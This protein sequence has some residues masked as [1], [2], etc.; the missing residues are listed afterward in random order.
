MDRDVVTDDGTGWGCSNV[1]TDGRGWGGSDPNFYRGELIAFARNPDNAKLAS[2]CAAALALIAAAAVVE[3]RYYLDADIPRAVQDVRIE[4]AIA[5]VGN[6]FSETDIVLRPLHADLLRR[7]YKYLSKNIL[8][9]IAEKDL[10]IAD[11]N[12]RIADLE[13][14]LK[15]NEIPV[16]KPDASRPMP[17]GRRCFPYH[18][19]SKPFVAD[20]P[21]RQLGYQQGWATA[22][23]GDGGVDGAITRPRFVVLSRAILQLRQRQSL[24]SRTAA[25]KGM[26]MRL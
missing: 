26:R 11:K 2:E 20:I 21:R 13:A 9:T 19:H 5:V 4:V 23:P 8:N 16:P 12:R 14:E 22:W 1:V 7:Q 6:L 3:I 17:L 15:R 25:S 24:T 18:P 10:L